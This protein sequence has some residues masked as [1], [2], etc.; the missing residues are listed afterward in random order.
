[1]PQLEYVLTD[2]IR[3]VYHPQEQ[4]FLYNI[5]FIVRVCA[6]KIWLT[7]LELTDECHSLAIA[8][9]DVM[10]ELKEIIEQVHQV[11]GV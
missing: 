11:E 5:D 10:Q 9:D 6:V 4:S 1:M 3:G 2:M 8:V 7:W